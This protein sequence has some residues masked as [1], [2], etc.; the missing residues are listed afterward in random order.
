MEE[1]WTHGTWTVR[2]GSEDEFVE[3]WRSMA[4]WTAAEF[5]SATGT[6]LR[7]RERSNVFI[8]FGPWPDL[9]TVGRWRSSEGFQERVAKIQGLLDA[10]EP[11]TLDLVTQVS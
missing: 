2:P 9:Q 5:A 11:R 3:A 6:L 1:V 10:F 7:D 8:S 4:E